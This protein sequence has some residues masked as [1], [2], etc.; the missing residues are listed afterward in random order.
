MKSLRFRNVVLAAA[1]ASML[2][3]A[4]A[5]AA[6]DGHVSANASGALPTAAEA[7]AA[8]RDLWIGHVFWVRNVVVATFASNPPAAKAA[9]SEVVANARSIANAIEPYYGKQ[10]ADQLFTLLAGHYGAVKKFLEAAAAGQSTTQEA[11]F[12]ALKDN[13]SQIAK[14]LSAAN[15]NLPFD[16]LSGLLI[17]HGAHHVQQID[18]I[19]AGKYAEE[20]KT[21]TSMKDHMYVIADAMAAALAKQFPEKFR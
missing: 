3:A 1:A 18:E 11:L 7:A 20:A 17:A 8:L 2:W 9:E 10:A 5:L 16:T 15:P 12:T 4:P 13:A 6:H 14:F 21:W 19:H